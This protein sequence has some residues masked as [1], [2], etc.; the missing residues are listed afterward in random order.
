MDAEIDHLHAGIPERPSNNLNP[1]VVA[2]E[3]DFGNQDAERPG[4]FANSDSRL[5]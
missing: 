2:V 3:T 1:A 5:N 4:W